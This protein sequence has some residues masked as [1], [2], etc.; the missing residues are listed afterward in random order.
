M[1]RNPA[2]NENGAQ[3]AEK[4]NAS[5]SSHCICMRLVPFFMSMIFR[6]SS[7]RELGI[8]KF[9][10]SRDFSCARGSLTDAVRKYGHFFFYFTIGR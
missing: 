1:G 8:F 10:V 3:R 4:F 6:R 7:Y 5:R 2:E 9:F